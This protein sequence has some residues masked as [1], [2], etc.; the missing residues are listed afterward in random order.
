MALGLLDSHGAVEIL[1][2]LRNQLVPVRQNQHAAVTMDVRERDRL[3]QPGRHLNQVGT[4]IKV[5]DY[6]DTFRLVIPQLQTARGHVTPIPWRP[7]R[8]SWYG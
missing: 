5:I 7:C 6:V 3:A 2:R 8:E 4:A 1:N